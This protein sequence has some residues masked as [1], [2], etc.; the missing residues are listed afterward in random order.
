MYSVL[1]S[2]GSLTCVDNAAVVVPSPRL[3]SSGRRENAEGLHLFLGFT[4]W[5]YG[6][7][8]VVCSIE[9]KL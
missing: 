9:I 5:G 3:V 8:E 7:G 4:D 1:R 6:I 2:R